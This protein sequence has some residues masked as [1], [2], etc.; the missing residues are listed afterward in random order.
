[1]TL[2]PF[3]FD[4]SSLTTAVHIRQYVMQYGV[5]A[6][7]LSWPLLYSRSLA[8]RGGGNIKFE[9]PETIHRILRENFNHASIRTPTLTSNS[10]ASTPCTCFCKHPPGVHSLHRCGCSNDRPPS[11]PMHITDDAFHHTW[12]QICLKF[13]SKVSACPTDIPLYQLELTTTTRRHDDSYV[14]SF[15]M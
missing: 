5:M 2:L 13:C 9:G 12:C 11:D 1:M 15:A 4:A 8:R 3:R 10:M 7:M 6:A 14:P